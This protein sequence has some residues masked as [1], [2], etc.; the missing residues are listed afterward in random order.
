MIFTSFIKATYREL[1][2]ARKQSAS[3]WILF[4]FLPTFVISRLLVHFAPDLFINIH[5]THIHHLTWGIFLLAIA[6]YLGLTIKSDRN[7]PWIAGLFGIGLALSFDE[8]GMWL[9]LQDDYWMRQSYDAMLI[10][11]VILIN[12]VYF[13][14]FW[15]R[16]MQY[17]FKN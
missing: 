10:I 13:Y 16:I 1:I 5:G 7:E 12:A 15:L 17:L 3:F 11:T 14:K 4:T 6:G 8:F 9:R 2:A